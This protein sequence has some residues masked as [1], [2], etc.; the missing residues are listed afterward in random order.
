MA[1][2]QIPQDLFVCAELGL[3][4]PHHVSHRVFEVSVLITSEPRESLKEKAQRPQIGHV[5]REA[6]EWSEVPLADRHGSH[7]QVGC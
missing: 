6:R 5:I 1:L 2:G 7:G 3:P 4:V